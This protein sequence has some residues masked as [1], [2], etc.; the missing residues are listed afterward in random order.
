MMST[1]EDQDSLKVNENEDGTFTIEWD[2]NDP[3]YSFLND[4]TEEQI[5][6][7]LTR[8]LEEQVKKWESEDEP[9]NY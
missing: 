8:G 1:N 7:L 3:R 5:T 6:E 9:P 2:G 4:L